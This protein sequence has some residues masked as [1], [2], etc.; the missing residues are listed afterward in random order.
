MRIHFLTPRHTALAEGD[1]GLI[2]EVRDRL[3]ARSEIED[4]PSPE[5][6]D[7]IVLHERYSFKEWRYIK[8]L[9]ADPVVGRYPHKVYTINL[10]DAA[11]GLL[12]GVYASM[13]RKRLRAG[14]HRA[15][16]YARVP[17]EFVLT[18]SDEPHPPPTHLATWRGNPLSNA[19]L[20][21]RL[22]SLYVNSPTIKVE[23][24]D[25]WLNHNVDERRHYVDLLLSAHFALCPAGWAPATFRI[26]ESMAIGVPPVIIADQ[27]TPPEGPEW[28]RF[29]IQVPEKDLP[30]LEEILKAHVPKAAE[31]GRE[32]RKAWLQYFR[33][34]QMMQY[35]ADALLSCM[36]SRRPSDSA[37][38]EI[39]RW[40]SWS[41]YWTND[42]TLPQRANIKLRR[43]LFS[44][45][46]PTP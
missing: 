11:S 24:T 8:T 21:Q 45:A 10:D 31:M 42:W 27:Y 14:L 18:A 41:T 32:A 6:A 20:R 35:Y 22:L 33:P 38:Q 37:A 3:V 9:L 15:I 7:A 2:E 36:Q 5:A 19:A 23:S 25:S 30:R 44:R 28:G 29:S 16:P 34:D 39:A 17:N 1:P 26:Y 43:H 40:R 46:T 4:C 13:P 12:R